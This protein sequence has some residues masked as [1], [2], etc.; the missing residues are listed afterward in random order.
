MMGWSVCLSIPQPPCK[1][2]GGNSSG[3]PAQLR[4]SIKM[5]RL[6]IFNQHFRKTLLLARPEIIGPIGKL[7]LRGHRHAAKSSCTSV[8]RV[9]LLKMRSVAKMHI[10][11]S[12]GDI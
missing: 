11:V 7:V 8:A 2:R 12:P 10:L 9:E 4:N 3:F 5:K 6:L 1:K